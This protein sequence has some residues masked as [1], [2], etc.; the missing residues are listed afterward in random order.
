MRHSRC[1]LFDGAGSSAGGVAIAIRKYNDRM[2]R[3]WLVW[4]TLPT[5]S[6][7]R[8]GD[9][10][11]RIFVRRPSGERRVLAERRGSMAPPDWINGWLCFEGENEKRRLAPVPEEW[12]ICSDEEL[13]RYC[14]KATSSVNAVRTREL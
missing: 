8:S 3:P 7:V 11:R 14:N 4:K 1:Y 5:F 12:E 10:R 13:E 6:P 2:G 9:E